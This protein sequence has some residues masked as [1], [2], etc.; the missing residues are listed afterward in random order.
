LGSQLAFAIGESRGGQGQDQ[1]RGQSK[2]VHI[3][4][5]FSG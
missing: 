5:P 2:A 4:S 3:R 1:G